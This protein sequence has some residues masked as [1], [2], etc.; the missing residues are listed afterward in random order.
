MEAPVFSVVIPTINRIEA[1]K[2]TIESVLAQEYTNLECVVIDNNKDDRLS[3]ICESF[4]DSRLRF[5]KTGGLSM[6]DNWEAALQ[7]ARGQFVVL[8]EDK[9]CLFG[10]ALLVAQRIIEKTGTDFLLW[11]GDVVNDLNPAAIRVGS[12]W[13]SRRVRT[14]SSD[15]VLDELTLQT[16]S[17]LKAKLGFPRSFIGGSLSVVK[18]TLLD[19]IRA[20]TGGAVCQPVNPDFTMGCQLMNRLPSYLFFEGSMTFV[21]SLSTSTG[22]NWHSQKKDVNNFWEAYGGHEI[23]YRHVPIKSIFIESQHFNDYAAMAELLGGRLA[24]HP[25]NW[26]MYYIVMYE[27]NARN[28]R[29]GLDRTEELAAWRAGLARE[30][31]ATRSTVRR[32]L[33][34]EA[35]KRQSKKFRSSSGLRAIER[36]FKKRKPNSAQNTDRKI[37]DIREFLRQETTRLRKID[38][39][40]LD[41]AHLDDFDMKPVSQDYATGDGRN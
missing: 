30:P 41:E 24:K 3:G 14:V 40:Y 10:H 7:S 37:N 28:H 17:N 22:G 38:L 6:T 19:E 2:L 26:T 4:Q 18:K 35:V 27:Q 5:V 13:G 8:I 20:E 32:Y 23:G 1:L 36:L 31:F 39:A 29:N 9:K 33:F 15:E 12:S 21:H 11:S 34:V 16:H 25:I